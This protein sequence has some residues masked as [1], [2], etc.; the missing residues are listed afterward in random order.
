[1]EEIWG[2]QFGYRLYCR[3]VNRQKN[4]T[5]LK[6]NDIRKFSDKP[7]ILNIPRSIIIRVAFTRATAA[8]LKMQIFVYVICCVHGRGRAIPYKKPKLV[9]LK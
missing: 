3:A 6:K 4:G 1:M 8:L 5:G 7:I 9:G 2:Y